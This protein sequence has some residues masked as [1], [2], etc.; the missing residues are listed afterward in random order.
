[1]NEFKSKGY[2]VHG[3]V[4]DVGIK[5]DRTNL[6]SKTIEKYGKINYL[7]PNAAIS[8]GPSKFLSAKD[9]ELQDMWNINYHSVFF[10]VQEALPHL[11][12]EKGNAIVILASNS[13][14]ELHQVIG[15]YAITKTAVIA[16]TKMLSK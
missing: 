3:I 2:E 10:L 7:V 15:Q 11:K 5:A 9:P 8:G 1:V 12:K 14:H 6:I 13:G 16:L 4:C